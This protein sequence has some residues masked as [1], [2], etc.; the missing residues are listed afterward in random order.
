M[1]LITIALSVWL[2]TLQ[3]QA[4]ANDYTDKKTFERDARQEVLKE[5]SSREEI[6][7]RGLVA[8]EFSDSLNLCGEIGVADS[9]DWV[10]F[11]KTFDKEAGR[12]NSVWIEPG[13]VRSEVEEF[14]KAQFETYWDRRCSSL[15]S[16]H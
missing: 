16:M 3:C 5:Q 7:F 6:Q 12:F 9:P 14:K 4:Q 15:Y 2:M 13:E 8:T 1:R 10:R 11:I